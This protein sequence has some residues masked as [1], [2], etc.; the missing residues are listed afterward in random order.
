MVDRI[1]KLNEL[2]SQRTE[3]SALALRRLTGPV[4]LTPEK[5]DV[6]R[7]NFRV[8]VGNGWNTR[9]P[10]RSRTYTPSRAITWR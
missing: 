9:A 5:P 2:L 8:R 7:V 4:S 1:Q 6:G 3:Q 10:P